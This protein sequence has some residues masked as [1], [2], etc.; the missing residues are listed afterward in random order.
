[1][2]RSD[3]SLAEQPIERALLGQLVITYLLLLEQTRQELRIP[4]VFFLTDVNRCGYARKH[5]LVEWQLC[6]GNMATACG[7]SCAEAT[8]S[9]VA[10]LFYSSHSPPSRYLWFSNAFLCAR[11]H[12]D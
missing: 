4:T 2:L 3:T 11:T 6:C 7:V 5:A 9:K 1:M 10:H 8:V 12:F